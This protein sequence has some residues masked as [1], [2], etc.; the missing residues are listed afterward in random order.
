M[1]RRNSK[2]QPAMMTMRFSITVPPGIAARNYIDL[3]Q[4]ASILNR[5]FYRQGLNWA[6]AGFK[7]VTSG[8]GVITV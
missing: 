5:R 7:L 2:I 1:A 4:S 6:V 8:N 3:S